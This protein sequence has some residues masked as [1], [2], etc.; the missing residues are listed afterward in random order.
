MNI[1]YDTHYGDDYW[2]GRKT[3]RTADGRTHV[4]HGPSLVWDGFNAI[5][6]TLAGLLP[7]GTLLDIGCGSGDLARRMLKRGFDAYGVDISDYA[8]RNAVP[9]MRGRLT[10]ADITTCPKTLE[11]PVLRSE[12][13]EKNRFPDQFDVLMATDLLE[14]IYEED[15][16]KTFDWMMSKT[17]TWM[18]FCV[19]T[20]IPPASPAFELNK[21][22]FVHKKGEPIPLEWEG[23]AVSGHVNVRVF[24]YWAKFFQEKGL[25]IDWQRMY[26]F[27]AKREMNKAWRDTGGWNMQTTFVLKKS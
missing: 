8:V 11:P 2:T 6:D 19:A 20:A 15:L 27:Q 7:A 5:A 13:P 3:Y 1:D 21:I 12:T 22:E 26:L 14:H 10:L 18:F 25:K 17:K 23:T 24:G 16:N 4:Y 9:E